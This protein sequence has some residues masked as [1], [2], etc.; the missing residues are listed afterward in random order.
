MSASWEHNLYFE[1]K[2]E[3]NGGEYIETVALLDIYHELDFGISTT[4]T[5]CT[6]ID[7][8]YSPRAF[9]SDFPPQFWQKMPHWNTFKRSNYVSLYDE[10][11]FFTTR[12]S[13]KKNEKL[14]VQKK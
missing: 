14:A 13:A 7:Y 11:V 4:S 2:G 9:T 3:G 6:N 8:V 5:V 1:R 12:W 10:S